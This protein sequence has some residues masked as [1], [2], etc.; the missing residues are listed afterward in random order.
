ML[1]R[2]EMA[3]ESEDSLGTG[4][5]PNAPERTAEMI[6][7]REAQDAADSLLG[8]DDSS[9]EE[10]DAL[11]A[12]GN[13]FGDPALSDGAEPSSSSDTS[14]DA[15]SPNAVVDAA[16]AIASD[17]GQM[18]GQPQPG[19]QPT[20]QQQAG[21]S[22]SGQQSTGQQPQS[23][24]QSSSQ[25]PAGQQSAGQ[26]DDR[27]SAGEQGAVQSQADSRQASGQSSSPKSAGASRQ[28][29]GGSG[30]SRRTEAVADGPL[31]QIDGVGKNA[32]G[33]AGER[34]GD[35]SA[36]AAGK[37]LE[38]EPWFAKLPPEMRKAIRAKSQRRAPRGYEEKLDRYF[39]NIDE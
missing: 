36:D 5:V 21:Q 19:G 26:A 24:Q 18:A 32:A 27:Q 17:R 3:A 12:D 7:G 25:S 16:Q 11:A 38:R 20:A 14:S 39:Q 15:A 4:F 13:D 2:S 34:S 23:K 22:Q 8:A 1:R 31:R 35:A 6:A 9:F 29:D 33:R 10:A 30:G 28:G 37:S